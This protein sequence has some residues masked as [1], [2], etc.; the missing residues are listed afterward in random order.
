LLARTGALGNLR[1]GPLDRLS[2]PVGTGGNV[3]NG[4]APSS[5]TASSTKPT[6][7]ELYSTHNWTVQRTP[8]SFALSCSS[9]EKN[10]KVSQLPPHR[11][12]G[13][14]STMSSSFPAT[15]RLELALAAKLKPQ[16]IHMPNTI[17]KSARRPL[18]TLRLQGK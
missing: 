8:A 13:A 2:R 11:H 18:I 4:S 17:I 10:C 7:Y 1:T 9:F 15:V 5:C 3:C 14:A 16:K 12:L 6:E